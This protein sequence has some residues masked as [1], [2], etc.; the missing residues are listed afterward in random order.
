MG[1]KA[2]RFYLFIDQHQ[3]VAVSFHRADQDPFCRGFPFVYMCNIIRHLPP[4]DRFNMA[5]ALISLLCLAATWCVPA[6]AR[7]GVPDPDFGIAGIAELSIPGDQASVIVRAMAIDDQGRILVVGKHAGIQIGISGFV[8]RLLPSGQVDSSFANGGWFIMPVVPELDLGAGA[9]TI[10]DAVV[11]DQGTIYLAGYPKDGS[12]KTCALVVALTDTGALKPGFGTS[13]SGAFCG[14]EGLPLGDQF[15]INAFN[16]R[17]GLAV[18]E[19]QLLVTVVRL[20]G[21]I[22]FY[23]KAEWIL[24]LT[25]GGAI[26]TNFANQGLMTLDQ[27]FRTGALALDSQDR[28]ILA[29]MNNVGAEFRRLLLP[30]GVADNSF[31]SGGRSVVDF[32]GFGFYPEIQDTWIMSGDRPTARFKVYMDSFGNLGSWEYGF[33]RVTENGLPDASVAAQPIDTSEGF[34]AHPTLVP[35]E[36]TGFL[37]TAGT[38]DH[39]GRVLIAGP[40]LVRLHLDGQLDLDFADAGY[41]D[42]PQ[43]YQPVL[44]N[45]GY[46]QAIAVDADGNAYVAT[47]EYTNASPGQLAFRVI[48]FVGDTLLD[49]GFE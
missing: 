8:L 27:G 32:P 9:L 13:G 36:Q 39:L 28:L 24:G 12:R 45:G 35:G 22:Y 29:G 23:P 33:L 20:S 5:R 19:T 6:L 38:S 18:T 25:H 42:L 7:D 17:I 30:T 3:H 4:N 46:A 10:F 41:F 16:P 37:T 11:R 15:L 44:S 21:E 40:E 43:P 2:P 47:S 26:D 34:V 1:P 31:G 48:K 49:S 14:P